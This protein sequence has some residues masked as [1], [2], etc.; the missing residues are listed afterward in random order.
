MGHTLDI[1]ETIRTDPGLLV[2]DDSL[3]EARDRREAVK[4]AA[5]GFRG[6]LRAY[7]SGSLAHRTAIKSA[8]GDCGV[9]L[10]RRTHDA[11]GPDSEDE[12]GPNDIVEEVRAEVG[13]ELRGTFPAVTATTVGQ[14][15]SIL[16][17]FHAPAD[18]HEDPSVDLIVGLTRK[19]QPG[20]WIPNLKQRCWNESDPECHTKL[21]TAEPQALRVM[22]ARVIRLMKA[23]VR[24]W[25]TPTMCSF[26]VAALALAGVT[27]DVAMDEALMEFLDYAAADLAAQLTPDPAGVSPPIN[28][29]L[30]KAT[31]VDRLEKARDNLRE[32]L[33]H[34][35]D[36][37]HDTVQAALAR[38]FPDYVEVPASATMT[39]H[40]T[41]A[42]RSGKRVLVL[43]TGFDFP[44]KS[45]RAYGQRQE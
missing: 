27:N 45:T 42:V 10:D 16:I 25:H 29:P 33:D 13:D 41:S 9:V 17:E 26:N 43:G 4:S 21:L 32:A 5:M 8:D 20:I 37:D 24:Q 39:Q 2:T 44:R 22:R 6:A 35:H 19:D 1:L 28:L 38:I 15:R 23:Q 34:D 11:L 31:A 3:T 12:E 18:G 40:V 30:A 36:D 7:D 14:R